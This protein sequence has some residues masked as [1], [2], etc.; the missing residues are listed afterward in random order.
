MLQQFSQ[1][2]QMGNIRTTI[3]CCPTSFSFLNYHRHHHYTSFSSLLLFLFPVNCIYIYICCFFQMLGERNEI[4]RE[5]QEY[6][7]GGGGKERKSRRERGV[8]ECWELSI[9]HQKYPSYVTWETFLPW[10]SFKQLCL[11]LSQ[12]SSIFTTMTVTRALLFLSLPHCHHLSCQID[13]TSNN[14]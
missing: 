7:A 11:P 12:T 3:I 14:N 4:K 10:C 6:G 1:P 2:G 13:C 8:L 5:K 9:S